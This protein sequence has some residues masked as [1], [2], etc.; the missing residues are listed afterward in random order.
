MV[1]P[2]QT[3]T[4]EKVDLYKT[5]TIETTFGTCTTKCPFY[6]SLTKTVNGIPEYKEYCKRVQS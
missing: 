6:Q 4:T 1:C 5:K 2:W 3:V